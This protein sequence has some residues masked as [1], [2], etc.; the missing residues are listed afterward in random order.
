MFDN[1]NSNKT[2]YGIV[3][4]GCFGQALARDLA[5]SGAELIVLDSSEDKVREM[6]ELTENAYVVKSLDKKALEASGIQN[7]DVAVVCIGEQMDASI[8]TTLHLVTLGIPK[9]IAKATS[10]E[11]GLILEKLGAEVVYPERDMAVRL[12]RR[13]ETARELDIIQLSEQN[14]ISKIQLPE[15]F[16]G[17]SVADANLRRRFGLNIIAIENDGRVL[18]KIQPD[19]VFQPEDTLFLVGSRDGLFKI[20]QCAHHA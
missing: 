5:E 7:C 16:V 9:V 6:R 20:S 14:N 19:Y 8:L 13:L 15:Q 3:G 2:T 4:L 10:A 17:K 12:A 18:D 11:H 1:K